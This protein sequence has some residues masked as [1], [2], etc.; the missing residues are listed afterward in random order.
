MAWEAR[1]TSHVPE[2]VMLSPSRTNHLVACFPRLSLSYTRNVSS[3]SKGRKRDRPQ[4][5][6]K[7]ASN[8]A[9]EPLPSSS[10]FPVSAQLQYDASLAT[11]LNHYSSLPP[12][13]PI[14]DWLNHFA[15]TS[16]QLRDRIS[17]RAP[18]TAISVARSFMNSKK[19]STNNPKVIIEAFPGVRRLKDVVTLLSHLV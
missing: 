17:L 4:K 5:S 19:T 2:Y 8:E 13:P 6:I 16:P 12:L 3:T 7:V 10:P 1:R 9:S 11:S 18:A 14:D 15:Y